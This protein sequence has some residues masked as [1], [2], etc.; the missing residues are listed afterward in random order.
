MQ[1]VWWNSIVYQ[2]RGKGAA[3]LVALRTMR[4]TPQ[5]IFT[6]AI[7]LLILSVFSVW[8]WGSRTEE[9]DQPLRIVATTSIVGDVVAAVV[10]DT[11]VTVLIGPG[12]NPHS[13][14]PTPSD[15]RALERSHI[16]F[17]NG[18]GLEEALLADIS[19][20]TDVRMVD[21][22]EGVGGLIAEGNH[23]N[24]N[25]IDGDN[26]E[27]GGVDPHV[28]MDPHNVIAW[29]DTIVETLAAIAPEHIATYRANAGAYIAEIKDLDLSI[30][31]RM[32]TI[33]Q[34]QRRL[35]LG[36]DSLAYF[37]RAYGFQIIGAIV[38]STSG[39][40]PSPR[41][42][43]AL[44][45]AIEESGVQAIFVEKNAAT[46]LQ[47]LA[48]RV[49][50]EIGHRVEV[51]PLQTG[52]LAAKGEPGDTYLSMIRYNVEQILRGLQAGD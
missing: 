20:I 10:R 15:F 21:L 13:Y 38:P 24:R 51:I 49:T 44:V 25:H 4:G 47:E 41:T 26:Q 48:R 1:A 45:E 35:V 37:A 19:A 32:S 39:A 28:W 33:P 31:D 43:V 7:A 8:G 11:P 14:E 18:L 17:V 46:S 40:E 52:S 42:I 9:Q 16:V 6:A 50:D 29:V 34:D 12:D 22:S 23:A 3:S 5:K 27:Q 36:H 30:R 2:C